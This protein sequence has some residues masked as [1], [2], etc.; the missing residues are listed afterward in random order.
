VSRYWKSS[1]PLSDVGTLAEAAVTTSAYSYLRLSSDAQR[2]GDGERRQLEE[3]QA[4]CVEKG[5]HLD[6]TLRD[7]GVSGFSGANRERG[8]LRRFLDMVRSGR[9][10]R[11]SHLIVESLDRLSAIWCCE[12]WQ[13]SR[14]Y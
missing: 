13:S 1:R 4:Y 9:V 7:I 10:P 3:T 8:A 14:S 2:K 6:A 12:L 5:L 11:G